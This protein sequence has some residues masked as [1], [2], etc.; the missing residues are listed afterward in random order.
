MIK[1]K[2]FSFL[3][4]IVLL[5]LNP[6]AFAQETFPDG[7]PIPEWFRQI[8]PTDINK[9]SKHYR[10]TDYHVAND[11]TVIQTKNIQAVI[12]K[13]H[14]NGGGVVVIPKGTFLSGSLFFK[15]GTHLHLEQGAKLKGSDDISNFPLM[16]TRIEGSRVSGVTGPPA[17]TSGAP[18]SECA[19]GRKSPRRAGQG[20]R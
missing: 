3:L 19:A 15:K 8:E 1:R 16:M 2:I 13:A 14:E 11:S 7:T 18:R 4:L 9:L 5:K 10:I 6:E 20:R 17:I 12:N